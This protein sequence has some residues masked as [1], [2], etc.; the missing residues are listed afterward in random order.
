MLPV[1]RSAHS[2]PSSRWYH[3][4]QPLLSLLPLHDGTRRHLRPLE[5]RFPLPPPDR[6]QRSPE[7]ATRRRPDGR[8]AHTPVQRDG[9]L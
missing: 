7:I 8:A 4:R 2:T 1:N 5:D 6:P 9:A 3:P